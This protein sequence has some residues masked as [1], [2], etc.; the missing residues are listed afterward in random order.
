MKPDCI[1]CGLQV[2]FPSALVRYEVAIVMVYDVLVLIPLVGGGNVFCSSRNLFLSSQ[3]ETTHY[4]TFTGSA[5]E[6]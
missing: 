5:C 4:C 1:T 3:M 2:A 6:D